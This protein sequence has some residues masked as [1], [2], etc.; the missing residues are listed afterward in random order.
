MRIILDQPVKVEG[1]KD[2]SEEGTCRRGET[3]L[4]WPL[5]EVTSEGHFRSLKLQESGIY[6]IKS[7]TGRHLS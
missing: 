6:G 1:G 5:A 4:M 3:G 2:P 7:P